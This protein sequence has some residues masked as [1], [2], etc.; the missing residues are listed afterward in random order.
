MP[1]QKTDENLIGLLTQI[2]YRMRGDIDR[3][4]I[5]IA[6]LNVLKQPIPD[7]EPSAIK[8]SLLDRA[9]GDGRE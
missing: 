2:L 7:F 9:R 4:E 3:L 5:G 8:F 6:A 1:Q